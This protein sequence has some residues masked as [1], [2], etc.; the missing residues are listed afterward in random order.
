ML[1]MQFRGDAVW[2]D[3][4]TSGNQLHRGRMDHKGVSGTYTVNCIAQGWS[5]TTSP[6]RLRRHSRSQPTRTVACQTLQTSSVSAHCSRDWPQPVVQ[7][8]PVLTLATPEHAAASLSAQSTWAR[9]SRFMHA[10]LRATVR[11][12]N[13]LSCCTLM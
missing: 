2:R 9:A 6:R 11:Y 7:H 8:T 3:V 12:P 1:R 4:D 5:T 10:R 13:V